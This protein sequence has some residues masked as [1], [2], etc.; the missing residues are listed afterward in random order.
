VGKPFVCDLVH[1]FA[2]EKSMPRDK[3]GKAAG[4]FLRP[5]GISPAVIARADLAVA[6]HALAVA[7]GVCLPRKGPAHRHG[8][9]AL[10]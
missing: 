9:L 5:C 6:A 2:K 10:C 4:A 7:G 3:A 1:N 8:L